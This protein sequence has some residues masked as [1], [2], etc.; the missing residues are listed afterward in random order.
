MASSSAQSNTVNM[1]YSGPAW[2]PS[3]R[4]VASYG[5]TLS[6][7]LVGAAIGMIVAMQV[8]GNPSVILPLVAIACLV[9]SV[10]AGY[11]Q[12]LPQS[13]PAEHSKFSLLQTFLA[14]FVDEPTH[15]DPF[16][17]LLRE[18]QSQ[19]GA[20][21]AAIYIPQQVGQPIVLLAATPNSSLATHASQLLSSWSA[22]A[23]DKQILRHIEPHKQHK[24]QPVSIRLCDSGQACC[25]YLLLRIPGQLA[26]RDEFIL[27]ALGEDLASIICSV[28][29]AQ[30]SYRQALY[31]ERS[32]IARELHDSLAQ[33][34]SYL[35][36]QVARLQALLIVGKPSQPVNRNDIDTVVQELRVHLNVAYQQLREVITTFRL[37]TDGRSFGQALED[38]VKEFEHRSEIVFRLDNRVASGKLTV[39]QEMHVLHII[40]EALTNTVQHSRATCSEISLR[41]APEGTVYLDVEDDGIGIDADWQCKQ[42]HGLV[43]MQQRARS[44]GGEFSALRRQPG[45]THIRVSFASGL[46]QQRVAEEN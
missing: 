28:Q 41:I 14:S 6:R 32:V 45:G 37:S 24:S 34:L 26:A 23:Q 20:S 39:E 44:L 7:L 21:E 42:R 29:I 9:S 3:M 16:K 8:L 30:A 4:S 22:S 13:P 18:V 12:R 27:H 1:R 10:A 5:T 36:I 46:A 35:K 40:R 15:A 43:I 17:V 25:G 33:S 31:E 38:S 11:L 19:T 2:W